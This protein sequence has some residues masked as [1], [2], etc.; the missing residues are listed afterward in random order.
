MSKN[1]LKT[2]VLLAAIGGLLIGIGSLFGS[3]G[4]LIGLVF[5]ALGIAD[6]LLF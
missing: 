5:G 4:A 3:S 1:T 6:T 2:Y